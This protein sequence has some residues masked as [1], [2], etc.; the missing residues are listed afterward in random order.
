MHTVCKS[1]MTK[2]WKLCGVIIIVIFD[3]E[4]EDDKTKYFVAVKKPL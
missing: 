4:F 1:N 2:R 3:N